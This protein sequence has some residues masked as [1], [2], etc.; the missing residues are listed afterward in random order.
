[1]SMLTRRQM[2]QWP[3]AFDPCED[4][5]HLVGMWKAPSRNY[6]SITLLLMFLAIFLKKN[7]FL[8]KHWPFVE[9][10]GLQKRAT[11]THYSLLHLN[12]FSRSHTAGGLM[13]GGLRNLRHV[14][15]AHR[16]KRGRSAGQ[17]RHSDGYSGTVDTRPRGEVSYTL[18][19]V[20][21]GTVLAFSLWTLHSRMQEGMLTESKARDEQRGW[22]IHTLDNLTA[23]KHLAPDLG[24]MPYSKA[25]VRPRLKEPAS[26]YS[27]K[28]KHG[29]HLH[30]HWQMNGEEIKKIWYIHT[31]EYYSAVRKN[32]ITP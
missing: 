29:N 26:H 27:Q 5:A 4:G 2:G 7:F 32:K 20:A 6:G 19:T 9:I 23:F 16:R 30:V 13:T 12:N 8:L 3:L 25:R 17:L 14:G 10:Q 15:V 31:T 11:D 1:M 18:S 22:E 24:K 21:Q 28:P